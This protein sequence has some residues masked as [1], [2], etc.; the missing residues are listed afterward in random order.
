MAAEI[1]SCIQR[2]FTHEPCR[3]EM[4]QRLFQLLK[5]RHWAMHFDS[6]EIGHPEH[7]GEWYADVVEVRE[8][9]FG[10]NVAFAAENVVSVDGKSIEE[11][12]F[13]GRSLLDK[14]R[15]PRF[16]FLQLARMDFEVRVQTNEV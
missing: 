12:L 9:T 7:F 4:R 13:L 2:S 15:E 11:I 1:N 14:A 6:D 10:V 5:L 16:H 3:I 8:N